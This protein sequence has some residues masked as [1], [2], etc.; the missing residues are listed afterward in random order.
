MLT[1]YLEFASQAIKDRNPIRTRF[2]L[3]RALAQ[4]NRTNKRAVPAILRALTHA[5]RL[6][7]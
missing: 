4:A 1:V 3:A 7:V 2:Y 5:R 6:P